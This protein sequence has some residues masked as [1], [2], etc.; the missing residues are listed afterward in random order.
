MP[1]EMRLKGD[2]Q[3]SGVWNRST[4]ICRPQT[5]HTD[6]GVGWNIN[7]EH[8]SLSRLLSRE[9]TYRRSRFVGSSRA[10]LMKPNSVAELT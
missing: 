10:G 6:F 7:I 5:A 4:R 2:I 3:V 1:N 8:V 9:E